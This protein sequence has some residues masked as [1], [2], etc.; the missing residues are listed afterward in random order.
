LS[1]WSESA[2]K[3]VTNPVPL[4][5]RAA[6]FPRAILHLCPPPSCPNTWSLC[7][8]ANTAAL[9]QSHCALPT[10]SPLLVLP[11]ALCDPDLSDGGFSFL[12][13]KEETLRSIRPKELV[14]RGT[15]V[16]EPL[17]PS[18]AVLGAGAAGAAG[19]AS[20]SAAPGVG[21]GNPNL[22]PPPQSFR[23]PARGVLGW[24]T[25]AGGTSVGAAE[26]AAAGAAG[27]AASGAAGAAVGGA[28]GAAVGGAAG[29]AAAA[30]L[31]STRKAMGTRPERP[32][33]RTKSQPSSLL[34]RVSNST[35]SPTC[36]TGDGRGLR[37]GL[38]SKR[39][40]GPRW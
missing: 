23:R 30:A 35:T 16:L 27:D 32:A 8:V 29:G 39:E 6:F 20:A 38:G 2:R 1:A 5:A 19:A 7:L 40:R 4:A 9:A 37:R 26:G 33:W 13:S 36:G 25:A 12:R 31:S 22:A 15:L 17:A 21:W 28:A 14:Q 11:R 18:G 3:D 24:S 10:T 34:R